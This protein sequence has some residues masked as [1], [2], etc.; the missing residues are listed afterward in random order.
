MEIDI[1]KTVKTDARILSICLKVR[2]EFYADLLDSDG[3]TLKEYEGY[4]PKFMPGDH[5]CD[6]VKLDIDIDTGQITNW[7]SVSKED[8]EQFI[9]G[10][11]VD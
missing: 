7:G 4:V 10:N 5:Y 3:C 9:A 2:D 8:I 6:Y 11:Q 1:T